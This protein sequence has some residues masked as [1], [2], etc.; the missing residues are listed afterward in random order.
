MQQDDRRKSYEELKVEAAGKWSYILEDLAPEL[1][2]AIAANGKHVVCPVH[3]GRNR[4]GFRTF[5]D[6]VNTGGGVCNT[7]GS[8]PTGFGLLAWIRG[9]DFKDAVRDIAKWLRKEEVSPSIERRPPPVMAPPPDP[10]KA[11]RLIKFLWESSLDLAGSA[12]EKY[13][14][15]RGIWS[16]NHPK[17]L[18]FHP[19]LRYY[20][21]A[22]K[23]L[24]GDFPGMLAPV[25]N[26]QGSIV[27]LHRTFLTPDGHKANVPQVK[28]LTPRTEHLKGSAIK[29]FQST[30]VL[31]VGEGIETMLAVYAITRMPVWS[32]VSAGL[33]E[34]VEIPESVRH[35]VIWEDKDAKGAGQRAAE[36][37][38]NRMINTGR[39]VEVHTPPGTIPA[40]QKGLDWLD[41]LLTQGIEGFPRQW[42]V[43]K[44]AA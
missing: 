6:F 35:L 37:L 29:L 14:A 5:G 41:T 17:T 30:D 43:Y 32:A 15:A 28:K 7:C 31:G 33:L 10:T 38:A 9:Y 34:S 24:L 39:T 40:D 18:R 20:D 11:Q 19:S 26:P 2:E 27:A 13:L 4:D 42:R 8:N 44:P 21:F 23:T 25:K 12:A 3:G 1:A 36:V 16:I 22:S